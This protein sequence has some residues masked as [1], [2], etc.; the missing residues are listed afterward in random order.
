MNFLNYIDFID[1]L[2]LNQIDH[3]ETFLYTDPG[4]RSVIRAVCHFL[5]L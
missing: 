5:G 2:N 1:N 4:P 3:W